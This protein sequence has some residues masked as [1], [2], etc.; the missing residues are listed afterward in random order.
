MERGLHA[1]P[2]AALVNSF[3]IL[4][5][6]SLTANFFLLQPVKFLILEWD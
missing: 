2:N 1:F 6:V 5:S 3:Q 4:F